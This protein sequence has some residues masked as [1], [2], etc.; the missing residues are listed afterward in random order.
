MCI[1]IPMQVIEQGPFLARCRARDGDHMVDMSLVGS[2]PEGGWVMT[3]LGAAREVIDAATAARSAD[4]IEALARV[5]S[6]DTDI[7]HLF[8]DL[9]NR[10]PSLTDFLQSPDSTPEGH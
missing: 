8:S 2:V 5:M 7:D 9:I 10:E 3:F 6:G 4:A 1:G